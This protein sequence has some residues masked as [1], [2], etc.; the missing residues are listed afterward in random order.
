MNMKIKES[1][2][3]LKR[4][5]R[6]VHAIHYYA[7]SGREIAFFQDDGKG[8]PYSKVLYFNSALMAVPCYD[9]KSEGMTFVQRAKPE[10]QDDFREVEA[11]HP[12][13]PQSE[14]SDI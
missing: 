4:Q 9:P 10:Y 13:I 7:D 14:F 3:E 5:N 12:G 1:S 6:T 2:R 11:K 8:E